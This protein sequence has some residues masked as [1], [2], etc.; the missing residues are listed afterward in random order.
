M[1]AIG[2]EDVICAW[3]R[4]PLRGMEVDED[5]GDDWADDRIRTASAGQQP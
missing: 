2:V 1:T 5:W 3:Q 4:L